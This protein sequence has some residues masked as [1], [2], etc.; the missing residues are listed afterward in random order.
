MGTYI[1]VE[2]FHPLPCRCLVT[3]VHRTHSPKKPSQS[4]RVS[5]MLRDM[6]IIFLTAYLA[7]ILAWFS[8]I[9]EKFFLNILKFIITKKG[10]I[11]PMPGK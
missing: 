3:P 7:V 6:G 10:N 1:R 2:I 11:H 5:R 8:E 4:M 9:P